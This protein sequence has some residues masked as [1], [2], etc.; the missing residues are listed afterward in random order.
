MIHRLPY[1]QTYLLAKMY[2]LS[3]NQYSQSFC[4]RERRQKVE[5]LKALPSS[6]G[7]SK[8]ADPLSSFHSFYKKNPFRGLFS[9]IFFTVFFF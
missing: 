2:L 3:P 6:G 9:V 4:G 5:V 7:L 1:L 8:A